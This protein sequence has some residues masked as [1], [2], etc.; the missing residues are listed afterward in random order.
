MFARFVTATIVI[1]K[2]FVTRKLV[3]STRKLV[4][5]VDSA[6]IRMKMDASVNHLTVCAKTVISVVGEEIKPGNAEAT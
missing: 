2:K 4:G 1:T 5:T 3:V 6:G